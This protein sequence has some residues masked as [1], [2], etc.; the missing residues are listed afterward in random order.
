MNRLGGPFPNVK[1]LG[2]K[3]RGR[4]PYGGR[5]LKNFRLVKVEAKSKIIRRGKSKACRDDEKGRV[6]ERTICRTG[7]RGMKINN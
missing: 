2:F 1:Q 5:A 4:L 3:V 6:S 7:T